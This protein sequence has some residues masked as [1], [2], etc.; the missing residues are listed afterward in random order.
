M[1]FGVRARLDQS[2]DRALIADLSSINP[3]LARK[4]AEMMSLL[5]ELAEESRFAPSTEA[6]Q[7]AV[8][9]TAE[10]L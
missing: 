10:R 5:G 3:I 8:A 2:G 1:Q 6:D 9:A 4:R 7:L